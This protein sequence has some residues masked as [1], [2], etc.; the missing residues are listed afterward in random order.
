MYEWTT[1]VDQ[2]Y[3]DGTGNLFTIEDAGNDQYRITRVSPVQVHGTEQDEEHFGNMES[4][5]VDAHIAIGLLV[6]ALQQTRWKLSDLED[7]LRKHRTVEVGT[8]T[9]TNTLK[10]PFNNSERTIALVTPQDNT[11]YIVD[12]NVTAQVGGVEEII[13]SSKLTNGF[14]MA[15]LGGGSSCTVKYVVIGGFTE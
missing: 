8:V 14:K 4:G 11:D 12:V 7:L 15:F 5:I 6:N 13:V 10:Y 3:S 1:W 9:L 2:V